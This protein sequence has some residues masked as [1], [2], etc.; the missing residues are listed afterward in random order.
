[1][2]DPKFISQMQDI[3]DKDFEAYQ[4]CV[5]KH[6][7]PT[8]V[9][10]NPNK[11]ASLAFPL[12]AAI[13]WSEYGYTL[14]ER[15]AFGK[16]PLF[17]A[18]CYYPQEASSHFIGQ[19]KSL[20]A[21]KEAPILALDVCAAPGG[22]STLLLDVLGGDDFLI[23]NE[24]ITSRTHILS[25]NITKWGAANVL[26]CNNSSE[27]F[28]KLNGMLDLVLVDAPCSGEG[29]FRRQKEAID[30]WSEANV[31]MC[32][33][34]QAQILANVIPALKEDGI[35]IYS[36][37]THNRQENEEV[38]SQILAE[39]FK[40]VLTDLNF[41][42]VV[43]SDLGYRFY[44][45]NV[46]G[47]GLYVCF[48][49]KNISERKQKTKKWRHEM[50]KLKEVPD[51]LNKELVYYENEGKVHGLPPYWAEEVLKI[52]SGLNPFKIGAHVATL[53]KNKWIPEHDLA[54]L[55][56]ADLSSFEQ[57][58]LSLEEALSYLKGESVNLGELKQGVVLLTYNQIPLGWMKH[59]G[60]RSNNRYPKHWRIK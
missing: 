55:A 26:V 45:H 31:E 11:K 51:Y 32:A 20:L 44:P 19:V 33:E 59:L 30:E 34:R 46:S 35:L 42:G 17:H 47:E 40:E 56:H 9:R 24:Y 13:P 22:K 48:L 6:D 21:D 5:L 29:M 60:N 38:V 37:C 10:I 8:T 52:A 53:S 3:L 57:K 43:R 28:L 7:A 58:E 12:K 23:A 15:P 2:L 4:N 25:E 18:G 49:Q 39:G 1:M 16:D 14:T 50:K 41:E 36:T 27:D 54:M